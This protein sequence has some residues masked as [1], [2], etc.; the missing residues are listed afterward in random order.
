VKKYIETVKMVFYIVMRSV[1]HVNRESIILI[2]TI[3][4]R[5]KKVDMG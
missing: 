1:S 5:E 4:K 3:K 2:D